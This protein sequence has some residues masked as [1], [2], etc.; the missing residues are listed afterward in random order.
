MENRILEVENLKRDFKMGSEIATA[1]QPVKMSF[2]N[3]RIAKT[4]G[5]PNGLYWGIYLGNERKGAWKIDIWAMSKKECGERIQF[6]KELE[7]KLTPEA[8]Q[9]IL[10][11]FRWLFFRE[12]SSTQLGAKH[13]VRLRHTRRRLVLAQ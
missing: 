2:R 5:L 11:R 8:K 13:V 4:K 1:F 3:E 6:C 7:R 9:T 12:S 10:E